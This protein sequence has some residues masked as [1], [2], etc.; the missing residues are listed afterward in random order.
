MLFTDCQ[1]TGR[2]KYQIKM[3]NDPDRVMVFSDL[4]PGTDYIAYLVTVSSTDIWSQPRTLPFKTG[5][6]MSNG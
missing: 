5:T 3:H 6:C 2:C 1:N 4:R